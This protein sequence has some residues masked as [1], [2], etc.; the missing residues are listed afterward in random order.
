VRPRSVLSESG[1]CTRD[2]LVGFMREIEDAIDNQHECVGISG[3]GCARRRPKLTLVNSGKSDDGGDA[4]SESICSSDA[5]LRSNLVSS[6]RVMAIPLPCTAVLAMN[7]GGHCPELVV[8]QGTAINF[9]LLPFT[10][11][12]VCSHLDTLGC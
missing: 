7:V 11:S 10:C 6:Q 3:R 5:E 8:R 12:L 4:A 1:L 9:I 2:Q